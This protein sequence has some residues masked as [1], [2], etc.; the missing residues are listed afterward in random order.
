MLV[1]RMPLSRRLLGG[2]RRLAAD[3]SGLAVIEFALVLPFLITIGMTGTE[4]ANLAVTTLRVNQLAML[5]ADNAARVRSSM[6]EQDVNEVMV[7]LRFAGTGIKFGDRGRV[8][9]SELSSNGKTGAN[10]G[11]KISW[12]RCFG[13]KN[14]TSAYGTEGTGA[15]TA[16][17]PNGVTVGTKTLTPVN[18]SAVIL[19]EIRYT[20]RPIIAWVLMGQQELSAVQAFPVRERAPQQTLNNSTNMADTSKRLC[21]AAHLSAT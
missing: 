14:A 11:Y 15:T 17:I 20:Y 8:I 6:D 12:Q 10:A 19:A 18:N 16:A 21:D 5:A 13:S 3:R 1:R 2:S 7:G 9:I 4:V